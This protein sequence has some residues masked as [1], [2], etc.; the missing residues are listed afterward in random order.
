MSCGACSSLSLR[1]LLDKCALNDLVKNEEARH[2]NLSNVMTVLMIAQVMKN[3]T[4][5]S[6]PGKMATDFP[7]MHMKT[8]LVALKNRLLGTPLS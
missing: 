2:G 1:Y 6:M 7:S 3:Q 5:A 8:W 4:I